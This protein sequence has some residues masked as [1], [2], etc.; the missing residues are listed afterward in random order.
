[1][2]YP[3]GVHDPDHTVLRL[4]PMTAKY[5]HQLNSFHWDMPSPRPLPNGERIKV[6]GYLKGTA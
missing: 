3:G 5:Y 2:Y 6:R 4:R 1:M